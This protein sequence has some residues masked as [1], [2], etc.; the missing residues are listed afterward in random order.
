MLRLPRSILQ[1]SF[2]KF[3]GKRYSSLR[4]NFWKPNI[5]SSFGYVD[6]KTMSSSPSPLSTKEPPRSFPSS[7]YELIDPAE[8]IEEETLPTYNPEKYYPAHIGEVLPNIGENW[9]RCNIYSVALS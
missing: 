5:I 4:A 8:S 6:Y 3:H 2:S 1:S 7:D 9:I